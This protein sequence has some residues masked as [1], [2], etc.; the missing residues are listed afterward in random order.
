MTSINIRKQTTRPMQVYLFRSYTYAKDIRERLL[1]RTRTFRNR[2]VSSLLVLKGM[3]KVSEKQ[4]KLPGDSAHTHWAVVRNTQLGI[5]VA[6]QRTIPNEEVR[7]PNTKKIPLNAAFTSAAQGL[8]ISPSDFSWVDDVFCGF[9]VKNW[10]GFGNIYVVVSHGSNDLVF[11]YREP[12]SDKYLQ[13][14]FM[15]CFQDDDLDLV[16]VLESVQLNSSKKLARISKHNLALVTNNQRVC[17]WNC[18]KIEELCQDKLA[19]GDKLY[20]EVVKNDHYFVVDEISDA[21]EVCTIQKTNLLVLGKRELTIIWS[22]NPKKRVF[23]RPQ[24]EEHKL[25]NPLLV[26]NDRLGTYVVCDMKVAFFPASGSSPKLLTHTSTKGLPSFILSR[27]MHMCQI[28][29]LLMEDSRMIVFA[30]PNQGDLVILSSCMVR[31][32]Q[33]RARTLGGVFLGRDNRLLVVGEFGQSQLI[34]IALKK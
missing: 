16:R 30:A 13:I 27:S 19:L 5:V 3:L 33:H 8:V 4:I 26:H 11:F 24:K 10:M 7:D 18:P 32:W 9:G 15:P 12:Q 17:V 2:E 21:I 1:F 6:G 23:N 22:Q 25:D 28:A 29:V 34:A 31:S 14:E 20:V